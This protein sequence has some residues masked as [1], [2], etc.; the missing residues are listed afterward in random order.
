MIRTLLLATAA[1]LATPALAEELTPSS[2]PVDAHPGDT[3]V[4]V[5]PLVQPLDDAGN[6]KPYSFGFINRQ[7][8]GRFTLPEGVTLRPI[9]AEKGRYVYVPVGLPEQVAETPVASPAQPARFGVNLSGCE[10]GGATNG[11]LCPTPSDVDWYA[12]AGFTMAR[13]PVKSATPMDKIV[14]AID[15]ALA[16]GMVVMIDWHEYKWRTAAEQRAFW[17]RWSKYHGNPSVIYDLQNEPG[18]FNP[19]TNKW[20]QWATESRDVIAALRAD[21]ITN[22]ISVEWPGSSGVYRFDKHEP[23]SKACESA[24]CALDR[25]GGLGDS[26]VLYQAHNY[27]DSNGSGTSGSCGRYGLPGSFLEALQKRGLRGMIGE[28]AFGKFDSKPSG[29]CWALGTQAIATIKANP[30]SYYGVTWWGGGRAWS[31]G[32]SFSI[33]PKGHMLPD[34]PY[35]VTLTGR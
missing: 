19:T 21:G 12:D 8:R 32:Y 31:P 34:A 30:E 27:F 28:S 7:D 6:L 13:V 9:S 16:R 2:G 11:S 1:L 14:P 33:A 15:E 5:K 22:T 26:N 10:F 35:V 20:T 25:T 17:S 23:A 24:A 18:G 4:Q 3:I 29:Q